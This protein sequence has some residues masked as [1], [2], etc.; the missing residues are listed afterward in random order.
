MVP[1]T[2]AVIAH[3]LSVSESTISRVVK[4]KFAETPYGIYCLKDF[5]SSTAGTDDN[6]ESVSRQRV[7]A[8][9]L[10]LIESETLECPLSDQELVEK[11]RDDGLKISRRIIAKYR[12]EM[13]ILNSRLRKKAD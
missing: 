6:Y 1:L 11:L 12:D 7:K 9:I 5:F 3:D 2:Y 10:K 8:M 13:G 4:H